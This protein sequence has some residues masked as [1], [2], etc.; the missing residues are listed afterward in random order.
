MR[1]AKGR[2]IKG[3]KLVKGSEKGW[4]KK[5]NPKPKGAYEW[6]RK[7]NNPKWN[8]GKYLNHNGY[9]LISEQDHPFCDKRGYV[10]E[11]RLVM[12]KSIGRYLKPKEVVHHINGIKTDN[13]IK[14]L[15]L[16]KN[17]S[18]HKKHERNK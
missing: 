3:H 15:L 16:F 14:N 18:E 10:F 9:V 13:R 12:E 6:G 1:D 7:E 8:G 5:G 17:H 11:H 2:F 4:F